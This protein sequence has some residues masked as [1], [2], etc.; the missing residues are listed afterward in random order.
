MIFNFLLDWGLF[1]IGVWEIILLS[2]YDNRCGSNLTGVEIGAGSFLCILTFV[3]VYYILLILLF[4]VFILPC[5][6]M[7]D[8]CPCKKCVMGGQDLTEQ[9]WENLEESEWTYQEAHMAPTQ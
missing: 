5:Y 8:C 6:Y 3:R 7:P 1:A 9:I 4:P 2:R